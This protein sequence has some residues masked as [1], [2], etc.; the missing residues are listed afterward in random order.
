MWVL[1]FRRVNGEEEMRVLG[2]M[3]EWRRGNEGV[4]VGSNFCLIMGVILSFHTNLKCPLDPS[5][6]M[7]LLE[8]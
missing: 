5:S 3:R 7:V 2:F 8:V 4:R 1:G 6:F